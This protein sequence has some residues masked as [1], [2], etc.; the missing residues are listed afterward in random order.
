MDKAYGHYCAYKIDMDGN[1][2]FPLLPTSC[3][4]LLSLDMNKDLRY[5]T[6][7][8]LLSFFG[9]F[10]LFFFLFFLIFLIFLF[11]FA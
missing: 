6:Q 10:F 11:Y 5:H 1:Y 9:I 2:A 3:R 4:I 8:K 7:C